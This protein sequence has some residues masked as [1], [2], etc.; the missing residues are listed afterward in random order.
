MLKG[1]WTDDM[2]NLFSQATPLLLF[3]LPGF[4]SAWIF[5]GLTAHPKPS[6]FERTVEA[7]VFTFV[8]KGITGLIKMASS[9]LD[10]LLPRGSGTMRVRRSGQYWQLPHWA[11]GLPLP[12]TRTRS[13]PG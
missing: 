2:D 9:P 1:C 6:Q 3:L 13:T 7:L 10:L 11:S 4:L 5:Y 8:V 12:S